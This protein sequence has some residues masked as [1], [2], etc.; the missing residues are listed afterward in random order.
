VTAHTLRGLRFAGL[1]MA[2]LVLA[3]PRY[4]FPLVWGATTLLVEP[5][6]YER[7]PGRS[8]LHDLEQG[9]PG[10]LLRLLAAGALVGFIWELLNIG[11]RAKWI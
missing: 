7:S 2:A 6:V 10:R 3:W 8:L 9:R 11:A 5:W 1:A 4:C